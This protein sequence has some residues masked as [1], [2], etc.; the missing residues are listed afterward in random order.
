MQW[1][2]RQVYRPGNF[3][4]TTGDMSSRRL[5]SVGIQHTIYFD[6]RSRAS[7]HGGENLDGVTE[8]ILN[9]N[10]IE[11]GFSDVVVVGANQS[12]ITWEGHVR[13]CAKTH[14]NRTLASPQFT[15]PTATALLEFRACISEENKRGFVV[16]RKCRGLSPRVEINQLNSSCTSARTAFA[17]CSVLKSCIAKASC[18]THGT[19]RLIWST[20][21]GY[22]LMSTRKLPRGLGKKDGKIILEA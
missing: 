1:S 13:Y 17:S 14:Y 8:S 5:V 21:A 3:S 15:S 2:I 4:G 22:R 12:S 19:P 6:N 16:S 7:R 10:L 20:L 9:W 11:A 18:G